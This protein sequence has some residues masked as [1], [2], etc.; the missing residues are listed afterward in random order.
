MNDSP[1]LS[2]KVGLDFLRDSSGKIVTGNCA[3][4]ERRA[5]KAADAENKIAGNFTWYPSVWQGPEY[6]RISLGG[7]P[8]TIKR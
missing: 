2:I 7:M 6:Y 4:A 1:T 8:S 5:R 3:A